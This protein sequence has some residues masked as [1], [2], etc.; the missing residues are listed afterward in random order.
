MVASTIQGLIALKI[1]DYV[2][3][4]YHGTLL[5]IAV[6]A[7]SVIF[8]TSMSSYDS[9]LPMIEGI[10]LILHVTGITV[11]LWALTPDRSLASDFLLTFTNEGGWSSKGLSAMVGLTAAPLAALV[12]FD[13]SIH[14]CKI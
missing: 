2:W 14:M 7:F 3:Q 8:N 11:P 4:S 5:T 10:M 1:E 9:Y 12:G 6:L 13:C